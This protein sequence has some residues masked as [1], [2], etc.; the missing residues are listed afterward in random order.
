MLAVALSLA[1]AAAAPA[2]DDG[3]I[4]R[5]PATEPVTPRTESDGMRGTAARRAARDAARS[6]CLPPEEDRRLKRRR[7]NDGDHRDTNMWLL[8]AV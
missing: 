5:V 8:L 3:P 7:D 1:A 4:D 6:A 2:R